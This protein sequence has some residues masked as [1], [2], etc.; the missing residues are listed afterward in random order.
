MRAALKYDFCEFSIFDNFVITVINEG[1]TV[2]PEHNEVLEKLAKKYFKHRPFAY[3][4]NRINS[5]SVDPKVYFETS[6]IENLLAFAVVSQDKISTSNA[7]IEKLFLS[8]P[9]KN[10]TKLIDAINW[11]EEIIAK[12]GKQE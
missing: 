4:T 9:H 2:S 10:F 3:I 8:K 7:S 11:C 6:K 12:A 1:V 5:Y